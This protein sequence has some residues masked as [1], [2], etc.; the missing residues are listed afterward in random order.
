MNTFRKIILSDSPPISQ[1]EYEAAC[2]IGAELDD[3]IRAE[4]AGRD[5]SGG[6][7]TP[8]GSLIYG[9]VIKESPLQPSFDVVNHF[10]QHVWQFSGYH[11]SNVLSDHPK[12]SWTDDIKG[13]IAPSLLEDVPD[14]SI[15]AFLEITNKIPA[16]YICRPPVKLGEVGWLVNNGVVNRDVVAYQERIALLYHSG[17]LDELRRRKKVKIVE[18][19]GGYGGLAYFLKQIIPE[20]EY[21]IVDLPVSLFYSAVYLTLVNPRT[22]YM[23]YSRRKESLLATPRDFTFVPNVHF[24]DL[25]GL[26]FDLAINTLSFAEMPS[27]TVEMYASGL[28]DMLGTR[29]YLFEQ[30]FDNSHLRNE[31][32]CNPQKIIPHHFKRKIEITEESRWGRAHLWCNGESFPNV[33]AAQG[34]AQKFGSQSANSQR[35]KVDFVES[36]KFALKD[37]PIFSFLIPTRGRPDL[38]ARLFQS[39]VETTSN[40]DELEIILVIDDDDELSKAIKDERINFKVVVVPKGL[41]MGALNQACYQASSGRYIMLMNDD[42]VLRTSGWDRTVL[43]A[44]TQFQ[45]DIALIHVNDLLFRERLCTFPFLSR[46]ACNMIGLCPEVYRRYK[47]DDHIYEIYSM[48]AHLGHKRIIY[49]PDVV[50]EHENHATQAGPE[51]SEQHVFVSQDSKLY[52]PHGPTIEK[53]DRDFVELHHERKSAALKLVAH[54]E[55]HRIQA[56]H[57]SRLGMFADKLNAVKEPYTF[58][59]PSFL[60]VQPGSQPFSSITHRTTI[61]VVCSDIRKEMTQRCLE[62]IK[63]YTQ[64][65]DL[66]VLDNAGSGSFNHPAEMNKVLCSVT[67]DFLVLMDDDVFVEDGWLDGLLKCID[68]KTAVVAPIHRGKAPFSGA[69]LIGD[70]R[71]NHAHTVDLP[72]APREMQCYCSAILLIDVRKIGHILMEEKYNK[73]FFDLVHGF[74]VWEAGYRAV[75][76]PEVI[77]THVGGGTMNWGTALASQLVEQDRLNFVED[78]INSGRL[79]H[80]EQGVWKNYPYL[81]ELVEIPKRIQQLGSQLSQRSLEWLLNEINDLWSGIEGKEL[82]RRFLTEELTRSLDE[83]KI[84]FAK[85]SQHVFLPLGERLYNIGLYEASLMCMKNAIESDRDSVEAWAWVTLIAEKM[86]DARLYAIGRDQIAAR[87]PNHPILLKASNL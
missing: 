75:C 34:V 17:I 39:I 73:Y 40:L 68:D 36:A 52:V 60:V 50:F 67:T 71:G 85:N 62:S 8:A 7:T 3:L 48:L 76:T 29:G 66:L 25:L 1:A 41:S 74:M 72:K 54:I 51:A 16:E 46:T 23:I 11:L 22:S 21:F 61:A 70:G 14:W 4:G 2:R 82:F 53:D 47:I 26:E 43:G 42:V 78:W 63:K 38:V 5:N 19:G 13:N 77:V 10:R 56:L 86:N 79:A 9:T 20:A 31:L 80:L 15:A 45:D 55:A 83:S 84:A 59:K 12:P 28:A 65:Y 57:E 81:T 32:H 64:N 35:I 33:P 37:N 24:K 18:I 69:Y 27:A 44:F 30:N 58:R 87:N 49:L 6:W